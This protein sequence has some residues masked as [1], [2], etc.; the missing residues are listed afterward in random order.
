MTPLE[1]LI[2]RLKGSL[3]EN[4]PTNF[5]VD[6]TRLLLSSLCY[7]EQAVLDL[8]YELEGLEEIVRIDAFSRNRS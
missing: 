4:I 5:T 6:E 3:F 7:Q 1:L 8:R 2:I